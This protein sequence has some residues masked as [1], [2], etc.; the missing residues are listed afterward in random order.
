MAG[1]QKLNRKFCVKC[2]KVKPITD[3]YA[4]SGW[5]EQSFADA[6]CK[7][8]ALGF[9]KDKETVR[10][11]FWNNNRLWDERIWHSAEKRAQYDLST[12]KE[13]LAV[14]TAKSRKEQIEQLVHARACLMI[15]NLATFYKYSDNIK[16]DGEYVPFDPDSEDGTLQID[17]DGD[18]VS[19]A[20]V[21]SKEW[22]GYYTKQDLVFLDNYFE[23]LQSDFPLDDI[24][25]QD[26]GR[27]VAK[28]A[29]ADDK[30][31]NDMLENKGTVADWQK[32]HDVYEKIL[33]ST[34]FSASQ[35]KDK[36]GGVMKALGTIIA[37]VELK[38]DISELC[39]QQQFPEDDVDRIL[40]D[41]RHTEV[42]I[43]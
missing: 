16:D 32:A 43:Q 27:K 40:R 35:R 33:A 29:L 1:R 4:N 7:E 23:Q 15:M 37:A 17:N 36:G 14:K 11:Y 3:F 41:F 21:Y 13:Y 26:S 24:V 2:R 5:K 38:R 42:A 19:T 6:Y 25:M 10:E 28:A 39:R 12:N 34:N 8:C 22:N 18:E 31:Y 20:K 9:C 30:T